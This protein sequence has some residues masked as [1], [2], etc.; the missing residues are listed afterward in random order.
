MRVVAL[1][2]VT[3]LAVVYGRDVE[4]GA[5]MSIGQTTM[6]KII[7]ETLPG[8]LLPNFLFMQGSI[9]GGSV[10]VEIG[11]GKGTPRPF[12]PDDSCHDDIF[13]GAMEDMRSPQVQREPFLSLY[14]TFF[15]SA[16]HLRI[17]CPY[18]VDSFP[19]LRRTYGLV[20]VHLK[21]CRLGQW[22]LMTSLSPLLH[23]SLGKSGQFMIKKEREMYSSIT[24]HTNQPILVHLKVGQLEDVNSIGLLVLLGTLPFLRRRFTWRV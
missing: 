24:G 1:V 6:K 21:I 3:V 14:R 23:N 16:L 10:G 8:N 11:G 12:L 13:E 20:I 5:S 19:T 4:Y 2:M 17:P 15:Y 18:T 22:K 7:S 9:E